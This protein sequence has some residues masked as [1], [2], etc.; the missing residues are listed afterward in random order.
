M[1][2]F[3]RFVVDGRP[4]DGEIID[5]AIL[6]LDGAPWLGGTRTGAV[7][8]RSTAAILPPVMPG[9]FYAAGFNYAAHNEHYARLGHRP[10]ELA[11]HPEPGYRANS[12]LIG[13][14]DAI[15]KPT[16][17]TG[18]FEAEAELVA[19]IGREIRHASRWEA[20]DAIFGWTIG[21]D[22]S[23]REW[24]HA[25]RTFYRAK[26]SDTFKPMGPWVETTADPS[27]AETIVTID[28]REVSRFPTGDMIFD[29]VD[30]IVEI[31]QYSTMRPGDILWMGARGAV[32]IAPGDSVGIEITGIGRLVNPVVAAD[33]HAAAS[34]RITDHEGAHR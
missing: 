2:R 10:V 21:N 30:F 31:T 6:E 19:V 28:D 4:I 7:H 11:D 3:G 33:E 25:D 15:I 14:G 1:T 16:G 34:S 22:V 27:T 12:A 13:H 17:V 26:N 23:A 29:T 24:Q 32:G 9:T 20:E 8:P 18:R 5:D